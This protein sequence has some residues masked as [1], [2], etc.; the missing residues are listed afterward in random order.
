MLDEDELAAVGSPLP[1]CVAS[2]S[3]LPIQA[4]ASSPSPSR[5]SATLTS[6]KGGRR[7]ILDSDDELELHSPSPDSPLPTAHPSNKGKGRQTIIHELTD[8]DSSSSVSDSPQPS[9]DNDKPEPDDYWGGIN[10]PST[11]VLSFSPPPPPTF[12]PPSSPSPPL[13]AY[14]PGPK[15]PPR[16]K[17]TPNVLPAPHV[18]TTLKKLNSKAWKTHRSSLAL[19]LIGELDRGV[20]ERK[21]RKWLRL[22]EEGMGGEEKKDEPRGVVWTGKLRTTA[23]MSRWSRK[24]CSAAENGD[25]CGYEHFCRIELSAK[26]LDTDEKILSTTAH[27]L[28]HLATWIFDGKDA[29]PHGKEFKAWAMKINR[30]RPDIVVTTR[31]DYEI[32]HKFTW[33]CAGCDAS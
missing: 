29:A 10:S 8:S 3:T 4:T 27:E 23:G 9:R 1:T 31:H 15:P 21:V 12:L 22:D 26:V 7:V 17:P 16:R 19:E 5:G 33:K 28:C 11:G 25:G 18:P 13:P 30:F 2:T 20:F 14:S 6:F 32:T 24:K